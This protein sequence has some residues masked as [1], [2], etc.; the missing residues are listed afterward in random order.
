[1]EVEVWIAVCLGQQPFSSL[2]VLK[3]ARNS[4]S[5]LIMSRIGSSCES[6]T[7]YWA[8]CYRENLCGISESKELFYDLVI[9][10]GTRLVSEQPS[11]FLPFF[12]LLWTKVCAWLFWSHPLLPGATGRHPKRALNFL[13]LWRQLCIHHFTSSHLCTAAQPETGWGVLQRFAMAHPT[14]CNLWASWRGEEGTVNL[15][16]S[17]NQFYFLSREI[18]VSCCLYNPLRYIWSFE[19]IW[20]FLKRRISSF[21]VLSGGGRRQACMDESQRKAAAFRGVSGVLGLQFAD[22]CLER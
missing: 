13:P 8:F 15:W 10:K 20:H 11:L 17:P 12:G 4:P 6:P 18:A 9:I 22:V 1:M 7:M 16:L 5:A 2:R 19:W 3:M 21:R 14:T